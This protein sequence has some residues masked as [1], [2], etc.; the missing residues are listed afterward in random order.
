MGV[1]CTPYSALKRVKINLWCMC[2]SLAKCFGQDLESLF[3]EMAEKNMF[4]KSLLI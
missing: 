4:R 2:F 3:L 1:F